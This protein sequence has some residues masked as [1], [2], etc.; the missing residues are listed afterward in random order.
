M[1]ELQ[2]SC[3]RELEAGDQRDAAVPRRVLGSMEVGERIALRN[4]GSK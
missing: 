3:L 1:S 2:S 4:P